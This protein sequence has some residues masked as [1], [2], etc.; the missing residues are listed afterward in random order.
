M[1]TVSVSPTAAMLAVINNESGRGTRADGSTT[2]ARPTNREDHETISRRKQLQG[3]D[4]EKERRKSRETIFQK[5]VVNM[6]KNQLF[7][8]VKFGC[9]IFEKQTM[10]KA[11]FLM[12]PDEKYAT[13]SRKEF[14]KGYADTVRKAINE[15]RCGV[16]KSMENEIRG[17]WKFGS[18]C[19][20]GRQQN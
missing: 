10:D 16:G 5:K 11:Y 17:K 15:K 4:E 18:L 8:W 9:D 7:K 19:C 12:F 14:R 13:I 20:R 1:R 3:R 6:A 2:T